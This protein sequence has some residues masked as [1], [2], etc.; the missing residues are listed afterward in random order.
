[1]KK[2]QAELEAQKQYCSALESHFKAMQESQ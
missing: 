1:V 2:L